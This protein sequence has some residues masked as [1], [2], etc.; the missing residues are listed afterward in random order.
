MTTPGL[1]TFRSTCG[2]WLLGYPFPCKQWALSVCRIF[3]QNKKREFTLSRGV[4]LNSAVYLHGNGKRCASLCKLYA[5]TPTPRDA[6]LK[7]QLR[8][9]IGYP[10]QWAWE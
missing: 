3:C 2:A 5:L 10:K 8:R 1:S 4:L 9:M 7:K 6:F